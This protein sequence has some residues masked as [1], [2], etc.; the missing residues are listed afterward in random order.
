MKRIYCLLRVVTSCKSSESRCWRPRGESCRVPPG[1]AVSVWEDTIA[2]RVRA[3]HLGKRQEPDPGVCR[4]GHADSSGRDDRCV[5]PAEP[6][7]ADETIAAELRGA[8]SEAA[9]EM[10]SWLDERL[11]ALRVSAS[12]YVVTET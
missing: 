1:P 9:R 4:A 3:L 8:T 11:G 12:S 6:G 2:R 7:V 10:D 5:L